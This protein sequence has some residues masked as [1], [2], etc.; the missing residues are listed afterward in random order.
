MDLTWFDRRKDILQNA[1]VDSYPC[2]V[3]DQVSISKH[4]IYV[5]FILSIFII[6]L[7]NRKSINAVKFSP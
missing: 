6:S 5:L 7:K 2:L 4:I 3:G 1:S